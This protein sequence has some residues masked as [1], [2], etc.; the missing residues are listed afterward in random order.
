MTFYRSKLDTTNF[1]FDAYGQTEAEAIK[2]M[3]RGLRKHAEQYR[4]PSDWWLEWEDSICTIEVG[5]GGCY[6]D[7]SPILEKP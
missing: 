2:H 6:R 4:I 1:S 5:F 3:K 7:N